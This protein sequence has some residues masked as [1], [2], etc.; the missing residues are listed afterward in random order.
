M[1]FL[2]NSVSFLGPSCII[3]SEILVNGSPSHAIILFTIIIL[4]IC[5]S[6]I[7]IYVRTDYSGWRIR[8]TL[9][10]RASTGFDRIDFLETWS[11]KMA[12]LS[13]VV[14]ARLGLEG[15]LGWYC[16]TSNKRSLFCLNA[17]EHHPPFFLFYSSLIPNLCS[18]SPQRMS[19]ERTG[20]WKR[21]HFPLLYLGRGG[22]EML[23]ETGG[24]GR[25]WWFDAC[26]W[27]GIACVYMVIRWW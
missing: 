8:F 24:E 12:K 19:L 16:G 10:Q 11:S 18:R 7:R 15:F 14:C 21:R 26:G 6:S 25:R 22:L 2:K 23:L 9:V 27:D 5:H 20:W 3:P 4:H 17:Y 1:I 13:A